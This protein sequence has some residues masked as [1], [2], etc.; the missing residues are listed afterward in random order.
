MNG[1]RHL[2]LA[3]SAVHPLL[4]L[5]AYLLAIPVFAGLYWIIPPGFYA[6]YARLES[7]GQSDAYEAGVLIQTAIR[8]AILGRSI[9]LPSIGQ[10]LKAREDMTDVQRLS[11]IDSSSVK[12]E[13]LLGL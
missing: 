4:Y 7:A 2:G 11:S 13:L 5:L 1:F 6:P 12:F 8:K 9:Q 10:N 3:V